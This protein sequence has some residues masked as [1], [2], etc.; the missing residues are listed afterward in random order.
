M[1]SRAVLGVVLCAI[2]AVFILQGTNVVQGSG[3][4]GHGRWAVI[5]AASVAMGVVVIVL[6]ARSRGRSRL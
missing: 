1:R 2:G 5:G 6:A 3:M 4:S